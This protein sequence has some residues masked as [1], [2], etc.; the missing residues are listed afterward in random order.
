MSVYVSRPSSA[1]DRVLLSHEL[2]RDQTGL[3]QLVEVYTV[4]AAAADALIPAHG[5]LHQGWSTMS[6]QYPYLGV[7]SVS[8]TRQFGDLATLTVGYAGSIAANPAAFPRPFV[9]AV[10]LQPGDYVEVPYRQL[11]TYVTPGGLRNELSL[12]VPGAAVPAGL[13]S[14][15]VI[16]SPRAPYSL[17]NGQGEEPVIPR[18]TALNTSSSLK[19]VSVPYTFQRLDY[20]GLRVSSVSVERRGPVLL[21]TLGIEDAFE[22]V[23]VQ[24]SRE[25]LQAA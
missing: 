23:N 8:L 20:H 14:Q 13:I 5:T 25:S 16:P 7:E 3:D 12:P 2:T 19:L 17:S 11:V 24:A 22:F 9:R 15:G 21:V 4:R 6:S 18:G 10:P 1:T